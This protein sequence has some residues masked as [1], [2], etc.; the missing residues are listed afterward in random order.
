MDMTS[1]SSSA[2]ECLCAG[3]SEFERGRGAMAFISASGGEVS[4]QASESWR[5]LHARTG[6][7]GREPCGCG[8]A[9]A[10]KADLMN[11]GDQ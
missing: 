10:I 8:R 7:G 1:S 5:P 6:G 11:P 4:W 9:E 3:F 2:G